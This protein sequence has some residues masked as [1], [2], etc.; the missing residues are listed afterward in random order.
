VVTGDMIGRMGLDGWSKADELFVQELVGAYFG[1]NAEVEGRGVD[2][3]HRR[4]DGGEMRG[5][6]ARLRDAVRGERWVRR[7]VGGTGYAG[8]VVPGV[9]GCP[10][11][12]ELLEV[13]IV[14]ELRRGEERGVTPWRVM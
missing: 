5:E 13:R 14:V 11:A 10:V 1:R 6:F 2:A 8:F 3:V 4:V 7:D 12:A 9:V